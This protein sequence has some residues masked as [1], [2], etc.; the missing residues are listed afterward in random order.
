MTTVADL[1]DGANY[2][3]YDGDEEV[4][5][6]VQFAADTYKGPAFY[7]MGWEVPTAIEGKVKVVGPLLPP[8]VNA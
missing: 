4:W 1:V 5:E 3:H 6:L 7:F 8:E 2:W